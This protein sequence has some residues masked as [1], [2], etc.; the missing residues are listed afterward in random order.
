[1]PYKR[2]RIITFVIPCYKSEGSVG[3]VID[4]IRDVVAE[5]PAFDYRIVAVN[6]CSPD[7]TL[8]VIREIAED[9]PK[10]LAIDLAKNGGRHNA[11]MCGCHYADGDY[12]VFCDDDQQCPMDRLWDLLRPLVNDAAHGGGYDVA[13]A[14]YPKKTQSA[15]KNFGSKVNDMVSTWLLSKDPDLK[16]S[17]FSAMKRF[18]KDEVI[19]YTNPY[20]YLSGLML[21][22]TKHVCNVEME[23]RERTIGTGNYSFKK[24][25]SLWLNSFT[26]FSVK[27]LRL[28]TFCGFLFATIGLVLAI[29][30]II[31]K[32]L[33]PV[34]AIG[35]SSMMAALLVIGGMIM[36]MLGL[37]GEYIGRI[38]ISLNNAPQFVVR[39]V[40]GWHPVEEHDEDARQL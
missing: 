36:V 15:W 24:S 10:V 16:F 17:N 27:P 4:E 5:R 7:G 30:V 18:V 29:V 32:L 13:I 3:L 34:V 31:R 33:L 22:S 1:M 8:D 26:S 9:D 14:K 35:Y 19:K 25:F 39:N 28:A 21:S 40:Y 23:E 11:L 37:I 6:D 20:P 38:Y 12:I 2:K